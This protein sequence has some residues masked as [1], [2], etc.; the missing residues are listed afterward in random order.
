MPNVFK[1]VDWVA[2]DTLR[3]LKNKRMISQFF[4]TDDK[5][6]FG[7]A[8]P[9]GAT[10]RKKFPQ[11]FTSVEGLPYQPQAI[12]RRETTVTIDQNIQVSWE[13]DSFEQALKLERGEALLRKEY[14]EPAADEIYQQIESRCALWAA[15]HCNNFVGVLG[16]NPTN[17]QTT[18]GAARQTLIEMAGW[19]GKKGFIIPPKVNTSM[20]GAAMSLFNPT[21]AIS[22]QYKDGAIGHQGGFDW[23]ESMSLYSITASTWAG[24][25]EVTS[26]QTGTDPISTLTLTVTSG[27]T[28]RKG[29][30]FSIAAVNA[31][32]PGTRRSTG[33]PKLFTILSATQ[34]ISGTSATITISPPIYGP[35]S[36][37][38]NVD[39]LP[40]AGADLTLFPGTT[41]PNGKSGVIGFALTDQAFALA[42]VKL[43]GPEN[44]GGTICSQFQDP[45]SGLA[46]RYL[47]Q[48][49]ALESRWIN[50]IDCAL[51]F[52]DFYTDHCIG[53]LSA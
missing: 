13:W 45:D 30:K 39:A 26:T 10:L 33:S 20:V 27:D 22:K 1:V 38:Q 19:K 35:G 14:S 21:D 3:I 7:K 18:T 11:R 43:E 15:D 34:T 25:V 37:Y 4:N 17:F 9:I 49:D 28:F 23:Y 24:V 16:T 36:Q 2:M 8:F 31:A 41:A 5:K 40:L 32:N 42:G 51:G 52:G 47:R 53:V 50:R 6:D 46:V 48:F 44:G 12:N 29:N